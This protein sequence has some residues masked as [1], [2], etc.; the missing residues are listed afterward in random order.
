MKIIVCWRKISRRSKLL[1]KE[2]DYKLVFI[3]T[4]IPFVGESLETVRLIKNKDVVE[5]ILQLP[6]G[7]LLLVTILSKFFFRKNIRIIADCHTGFLISNSIKEFLLNKIFNWLLRFVDE[8]WIHNKTITEIL[9]EWMKKKVR[10]VYDPHPYGKIGIPPVKDKVIFFW[11][12]TWK[13]D[14]P[15][16]EVIEAFN[17]LEKERKD[18]MVYITGN[19]PE[20]AKKIVRSKNIVLTG[21][22]PREKFDELIKSCHVVIA[23]TKREYTFVHAAWEGYSL[24]KFVL[25]SN[26]RTMKEIY[27]RYDKVLFTKLDVDSIKKNIIKV[28]DSLKRHDNPTRV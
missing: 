3:K 6:Q 9:P 19:H 22:L 26:T 23:L 8:I 12:C 24:G 15:W 4:A 18:W 10:V 16:R 11:P 14:D 1:S 13:G 28:I 25:V 5:V 17:E 2:K 7:P 20:T 27:E 21:F